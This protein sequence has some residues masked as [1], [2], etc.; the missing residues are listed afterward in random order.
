MN[1]AKC[2]TRELYSSAIH[3]KPLPTM[4]PHSLHTFLELFWSLLGA[5]QLHIT[6]AFNHALQ[7][8]RTILRVEIMNSVKDFVFMAIKFSE[9]STWVLFGCKEIYRFTNGRWHALIGSRWWTLDV[10]SP[11]GGW[12]H[13]RQELMQKAVFLIKESSQVMDD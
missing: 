1:E 8:C 9:I 10:T 2:A 7:E 5:S 6:H 12:G 11:L 3:M 13:Q 4:P